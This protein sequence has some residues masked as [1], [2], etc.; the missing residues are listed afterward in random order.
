MTSQSV[1]LREIFPIYSQIHTGH[2]NTE[3]AKCRGFQCQNKSFMWP[4]LN[5]KE[6]E[7][8]SY[9][10]IVGWYRLKPVNLDS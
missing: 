9:V 1:R 2:L 5:L 8:N 10:D 6:L 4:S 7:R 3:F